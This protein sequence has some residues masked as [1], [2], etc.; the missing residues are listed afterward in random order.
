M[1]PCFSSGAASMRQ[2]SITTSCVAEPK[3]TTKVNTAV[4]AMFCTG[5]LSATPIN[6]STITSWQ[7]IIH[8]RRRP[9]SRA[10]TGTSKASM[11]GDQMNLR[12]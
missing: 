10:S 8:A 4:T 7:V 6:P 1:I 5:S 12:L 3:A 9:T 11:I 2:P